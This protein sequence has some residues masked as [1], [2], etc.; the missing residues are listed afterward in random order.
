M[1]DDEFASQWVSLGAPAGFSI[2]DGHAYGSG[3]AGRLA[4][5]SVSH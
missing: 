5:A 2:R 3:K 1:G 4:F